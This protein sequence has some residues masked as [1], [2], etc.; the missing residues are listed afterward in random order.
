MMAYMMPNYQNTK[1]AAIKF[2]KLFLRT[3]ICDDRKQ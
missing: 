1:S 3:I 2:D